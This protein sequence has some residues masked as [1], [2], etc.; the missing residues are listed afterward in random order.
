MIK[1]I[2]SFF[3]LFVLCGSTLYAASVCSFEQER[4]YGIK[5]LFNLLVVRKKTDVFP[6]RYDRDSERYWC[7]NQRV[8]VIIKNVD[9]GTY[10]HVDFRNRITIVVNKLY[11]RQQ[12]LSF[13]EYALRHE[14]GHIYDYKRFYAARIF[15]KILPC[16]NPLQ[17][18]IALFTRYIDEHIADIH[19]IGDNQISTLALHN[20]RKKY[21][22][23]LHSAG[24]RVHDS[25]GFGSDDEVARAVTID[26]EHFCKNIINLLNGHSVSHQGYMHPL[27]TYA[28]INKALHNKKHNRPNR[29]FNEYKQ[30]DISPLLQVVYDVIKSKKQ[31]PE[32]KNFMYNYNKILGQLGYLFVAQ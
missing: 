3:I 12:R 25:F 23:T 24:Y 27:L 4:E 15:L 31:H 32:R 10:S 18:V 14:L 9:T 11:A 26:A 6:V 7:G 16:S 20:L 13:W 1:N 28:L 21:Y 30:G 5:A 8:M 22:N 29:L 19:A 17:P 2:K